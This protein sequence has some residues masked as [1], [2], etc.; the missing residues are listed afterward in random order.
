MQLEVHYKLVFDRMTKA[1]EKAK[2]WEK[3]EDSSL[4]YDLPIIATQEFFH[5]LKDSVEGKLEHPL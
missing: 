5:I 4:K 1:M 2:D 3:L